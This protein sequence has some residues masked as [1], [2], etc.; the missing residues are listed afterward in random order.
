MATPRG[1]SGTQ[2][3]G[4]AYDIPDR[5]AVRSTRQAAHPPAPA[6]AHASGSGQQYSLFECFLTQK[7]LL[8]LR[9]KVDKYLDPSCDRVRIYPLC[10]AC[11]G[12]IETVGQTAPVEA[13]HYLV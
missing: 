10:A 2:F 8:L 1:G 7:E 6:L 5:A 9:A 12:K 4:A 13:T 11:L 3:Y